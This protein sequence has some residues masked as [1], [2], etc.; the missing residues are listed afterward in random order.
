MARHAAQRLLLT[1]PVMFG[2]LLIGFLLMQVVPTDPAVVRAGPTASAEVVDAIRRDLGL[3]RPILVQFALYLW[4]LAHGDLGVSIIN[5]VPVAQ[6]LAATIGPTLEL[7]AASL[8]WSV[9]LGIAMG[10]IAAYWRGSLADRAIMAISVAGVSVP[11]FFLGLVLIWFVGFQWQWLPFTG[12][13]GPLWTIEGLRAIALPAITLGG[14]FVG[15]VARMTR[16]AVLDVLGAEH[17][18]TARA[19]GLTERAVVL[20]HALRNALIP[21]VTLIGLQI[22]FLLG[23]AV[24]TETV[25]SWPGVGR[26]A[27]GAILSSDFPMAQGTI[28]V[29]SLGFILINLI[30]D[31]LYGVLDPRVRAA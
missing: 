4:R 22:G 19:K 13:G 1:L 2:V 11:V 8:I 21:V 27:V 23:G 29:L 5:N 24:V 14:V 28:I 3:D 15:P 26:L 16:T 30:V 18:R 17:V 12:R 7:M 25:F 10:T 20:R 9:P 31:L 6:E